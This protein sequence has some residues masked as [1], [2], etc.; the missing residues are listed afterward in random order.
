MIP[1]QTWQ[2]QVAD[3]KYRLRIERAVYEGAGKVLNAFIGPQKSAEKS[4]KLKVNLSVYTLSPPPSQSLAYFYQS[5]GF[6]LS[7]SISSFTV[8]SV[9]SQI[10]FLRRELRQVS[11]TDGA[12]THMLT[13]HFNST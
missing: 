2:Q 1:P 6:I 5:M 11:L 8:A 4:T 10:A 9:T 13:L 7:L 12:L 3:M